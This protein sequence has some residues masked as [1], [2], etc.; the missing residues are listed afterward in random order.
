MEDILLTDKEDVTSA[1]QAYDALT[2]AQKTLIDADTL[3][4]LT[5]AEAEI[6]DLEA[7]DAVTALITALPEPSEITL[8]DK[9]VVDAAK[10]AYDAL[11]DHQKA[12]IDLFD[13]LK[14]VFDVAAITQIETDIAAASD[15]TTLINALPAKEDVKITDEENIQ[16]ARAAYDALTDTQKDLIDADT[17]QK[18]TDAEEALNSMV[19]LGDADG[20]GEVDVTDVTI[21]ERYIAEFPVSD[22]FNE[23]AAD[24]DGDGEVTVVDA[25]ILQR[26][27]ADMTVKYPVNEWV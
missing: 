23:K 22:N 19:I 2:D 10:A 14:L 25:T 1:R 8:A 18:L 20:D 12:L 7:A 6:A 24:V 9:E 13:G 5:D 3:Q 17:L 27:L 26:Y 15:V 16:A 21:I 4:K 11:T